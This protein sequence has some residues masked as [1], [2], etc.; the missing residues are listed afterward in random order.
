MAVTTNLYPPI[1]DTVMPAFLIGSESIQDNI[2]KVYFSLSLFNSIDQ[3]ANAQITVRN[4][5]TNK[6]ALDSDKYPSEVMIKKVEIDDTK[7]TDDRYYIEIKPGDME[8]GSF[9]VDKYYKV[10]I[11]FTSVDAPDS[12]VDLDHPDAA[13]QSIDAWLT[14]NLQYFSEWSTVCLIR[15]ISIPTLTIKDFDGGITEIY[16]TI[17]NT[18][19]VGRLNFAN[20]NENETLSYYNI[21]LYDR[22]DNLL[23]DSGNIYTNGYTDPNTIYYDLNYS[24]NVQESYYFTLTYVT[25]NLYEN[26]QDFTFTVIGADVPAP[27]VTITATPNEE[28]GYIKVDVESEEVFTEFT[29]SLIIRRTSN[30]SDFTI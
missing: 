11:R 14:E 10:Q 28:N 6:S 2:C 18:Q 30:K 26:S 16:S 8:D 15:G 17:A 7:E 25:S 1:V 9:V 24:L 12:G 23:L 20:E 21:K 13:P 5:T 19:I 22:L 3:I 29:G 27:Q 4:Q